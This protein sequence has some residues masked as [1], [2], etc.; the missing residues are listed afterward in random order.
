MR[1]AS[2]GGPFVKGAYVDIGPAEVIEVVK[3]LKT[4]GAYAIAGAVAL[5]LIYAVSTMERRPALPKEKYRKH[6][7]P[8]Y[9][10]SFDSE[11]FVPLGQI[12]FIETK[13]SQFIGMC[14]SDHLEIEHP[15]GSGS[16]YRIPMNRIVGV[17]KIDPIYGKSYRI[18]TTDGSVYH[19]A[20]IVSTPEYISMIGHVHLHFEQTGQCQRELRD[21]RQR[22]DNPIITLMFL[23]LTLPLALMTGNRCD[24]DLV[25]SVKGLTIDEMGNLQERMA[26]AMEMIQKKHGIMIPV[27]VLAAVGV[28]KLPD[29]ESDFEAYK[30]H[31]IKE[32]ELKEKRLRE[33]KEAAEARRKLAEDELAFAREMANIRLLAIASCVVLLLLIAV[34]VFFSFFHS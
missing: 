13:E 23:P 5:G 19:N 7:L 18:V 3:S 21:K 26:K 10:S 31:L 17:E 30:R 14:V 15:E 1:V 2:I 33:E 12:D 29:G 20:R 25:Q 4:L 6:P 8:P 11:R 27:A 9:F 32:R 16:R 28:A 22:E 34:L 24:C